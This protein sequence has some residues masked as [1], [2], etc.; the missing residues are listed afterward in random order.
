MNHTT[1]RLISHA[2]IIRRLWDSVLDG[3]AQSDAQ[4]RQAMAQRVAGDA[5]ALGFEIPSGRSFASM[6]EV[7]LKRA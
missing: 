7:L 5:D 3:R 6:A 4:L 1:L 2:E